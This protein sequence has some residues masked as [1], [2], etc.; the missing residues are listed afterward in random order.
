MGREKGTDKIEGGAFSGVNIVQINPL[1]GGRYVAISR[2]FFPGVN[3]SKF[4]IL[5]ILTYWPYVVGS[6]FLSFASSGVNI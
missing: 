2:L 4:L 3:I 6:V 5:Y 1:F